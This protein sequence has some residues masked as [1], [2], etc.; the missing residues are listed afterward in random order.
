MKIFLR[1]C[2]IANI[3]LVLLTL[4]LPF[5]YLAGDSSLYNFFVSDVGVNIRSVLSIMVFVLWI[6]SIYVWSKFDKK[7][8]RLILLIFLNAFYMLFYFRKIVNEGWI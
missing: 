4:I 1:L 5:A 6:Y 8:L 2:Y 3:L 7:A